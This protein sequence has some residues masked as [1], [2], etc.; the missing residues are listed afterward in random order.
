MLK[1][2]YTK[3]DTLFL[4]VNISENKAQHETSL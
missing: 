4:D 3:N 2:N 1:A